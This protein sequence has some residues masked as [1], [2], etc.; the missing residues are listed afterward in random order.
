MRR[1]VYGGAGAEARVRKRVYGGV[2]TEARVRRRG[3]MASEET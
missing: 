3:T 1:R 2:C